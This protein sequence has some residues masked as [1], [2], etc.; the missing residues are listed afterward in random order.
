[1]LHFGELSQVLQVHL[2]EENL[3]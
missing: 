3:N 2:D 1:V